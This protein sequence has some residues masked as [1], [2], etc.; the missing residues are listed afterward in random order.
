[1]KNPL[2]ALLLVFVILISFFVLRGRWTSASVNE[3]VRAAAERPAPIVPETPAERL[4]RFRMEADAVA[5]DYVS[6][7]VVGFRRIRF[8]AADTSN[9]HLTNWT[10]MASAEFINRLGGV[11]LTS[12]DFQFYVGES[13]K[14]LYAGPNWAKKEERSNEEFWK[15]LGATNRPP[16]GWPTP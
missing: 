13:G 8:I 12:V 3:H 4:H 11:S 7:E 15:A 2:V 14:I 6:N 10:G 5:S 1:M 9:P 16:G